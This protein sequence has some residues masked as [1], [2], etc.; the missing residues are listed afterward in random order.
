MALAVGLALMSSASSAP[1]I[2][3]PPAEPDAL[4][5]ASTGRLDQLLQRTR[6]A[7]ATAEATARRKVETLLGATLGTQVSVQP[8]LFQEQIARLV[9][10]GP[11][12]AP[13]L[14]DA[15]KPGILQL[16]ALP[17]GS[18]EASIA[19]QV[20]MHREQTILRASAN[21]LSSYRTRVA[22]H[23]LRELATPAA[24]DG[25]LH[26][27]Q[28]ERGSTR[29]RAL[30]ALESC[31][32]PERAAP[33]LVTLFEMTSDPADQQAL[34]VCLARMGGKTAI[35]RVRRSLD[36]T[37]PAQ[38]NLA[39][40]ALASAQVAEVAAELLT[41]LEAPKGGSAMDGILDYYRAFPLLLE[42]N[43]HLQALLTV[44]VERR[45]TRSK[46]TA[47]LDLLLELRIKP[48]SK[49][50]TL[51]DE[52]SESRSSGVAELTLTWL[53]STGNNKALRTLLK[54]LNKNCED[55]PTYGAAFTRRA[56]LWY[57]VGEYKDAIEDYRKAIFLDYNRNTERPW[58]GI[59][60]CHARERRFKAAAQA[61]QGSPLKRP[62]LSAL[63]DDPAFKEMA[64]KEQYWV[65]T[66]F[67]KKEDM[68]E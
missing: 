19:R 26:M 2:Q 46:V 24:T 3:Q 5:S 8:S 14:I 44:L 65:G 23:A 20:E 35:A 18:D 27:I 16:P 42:D 55:T 47:T 43:D 22:A 56:D 33:S 53:A 59:A 57:L 41:L 66:F 13:A 37:N 52:L 68:P 1:R 54:P 6:R 61:L 36:P 60:R 31:P 48:R 28:T 49:S 21:K 64:R 12:A 67:R 62:E 51:A 63:V 34:L 15:L 29:I 30:L 45:V 4:P 25:L 10:L 38:A 40:S 17:T 32:E 58:V 39:L 7:A 11:A 50:R 9:D